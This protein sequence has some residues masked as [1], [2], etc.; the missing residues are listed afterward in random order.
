MESVADTGCA[1][2]NCN[3]RQI[4]KQSM[5]NALVIQLSNARKA[6][7]KE[8]ENKMTVKT[9]IHRASRAA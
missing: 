8:A 5:R 9:T 3:A 2:P 6:N 7:F 1:A 4:R